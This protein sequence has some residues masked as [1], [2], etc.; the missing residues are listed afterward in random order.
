[1]QRTNKLPALRDIRIS[2]MSKDFFPGWIIQDGT[3]EWRCPICE[4]PHH[5]EPGPFSCGMTLD[6]N[7]STATLWVKSFGCCKQAQY[8]S[9]SDIKKRK[10]C[11]SNLIPILKRIFNY[12]EI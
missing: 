9:F 8:F 6:K 2:E 12:H 1:M 10:V 5:K 4:R 3:K 7:E 11:K